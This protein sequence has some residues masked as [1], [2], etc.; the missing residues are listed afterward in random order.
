MALNC[1]LL[2]TFDRCLSTSRNAYWRQFCSIPFAKRL[3]TI[4]MLFFSISSIFC[5]IIYDTYNGI[6]TTLPGL[7]TII[8]VIYASIF[9]SL[10]PHGGVLICGIITWIHVRQSRNRIDIISASDQSTRA[11]QRMQRQLFIL[12]FVQAFLGVILGVQRDILMPYRFFTSSIQK[13]VERQQVEYIL[14]QLSTILY[15]M[16]FGISFYIHYACSSMFRK[17]FQIS[18]KSLMKRCF[19]FGPHD[20]A[21]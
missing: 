4:T 13:S 5:V 16:K 1:L 19:H 11:V 15:T 2:S 10:V 12:I 8:L 9:L 18:M 3:F 17:T 21:H 20:R 7:G 14:L 6:C